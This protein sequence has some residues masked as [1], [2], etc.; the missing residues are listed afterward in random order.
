MKIQKKKKI[1]NKNKHLVIK[2][3]FVWESQEFRNKYEVEIKK[4]YQ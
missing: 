4:K 2:F 3:L 1:I